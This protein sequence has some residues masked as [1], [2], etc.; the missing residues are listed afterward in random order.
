MALAPGAAAG[1]PSF[2]VNI[3]A[4]VETACAPP[5]VSVPQQAPGQVALRMFHACNSWHQVELRAPLGVEIAA[6]EG[7]GL[8]WRSGAP[9]VFYARS[10][11]F[12]GDRIVQVRFAGEALSPVA[13]QVAVRP[14]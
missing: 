13:L 3:R 12:W 4:A 6:V 9:G 14:E 1:D 2:R 10:G 11:P 5:A 8:Q 7:E